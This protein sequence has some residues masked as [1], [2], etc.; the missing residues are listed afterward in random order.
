MFRYDVA[1]IGGR[2][3]QARIKGED[4]TELEGDL[5]LARFERAIE[6]VL[7]EAPAL[8]ERQRA[9]VRAI[10]DGAL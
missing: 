4:T 9:E 1:S 7:A 8:T 6:A 5:A 3:G 10:L 2:I